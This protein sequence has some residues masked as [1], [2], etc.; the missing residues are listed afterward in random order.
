MMIKIIVIEK[1]TV[2]QTYQGDEKVNP[3]GN[4]KKST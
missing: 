1:M 2:K 3:V 4:W